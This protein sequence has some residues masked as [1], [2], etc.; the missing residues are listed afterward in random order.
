MDE[1]NTGIIGEYFYRIENREGPDFDTQCRSWVR[2]QEENT[3]PHINS[4]F[5]PSC[6]CSLTQAEL[7]S[8]FFPINDAS[9]SELVLCYQFFSANFIGNPV[10]AY[11]FQVCCYSNSTEDA[12][13]LIFNEVDGGNLQV[14]YFN[15]PNDV[16]NDTAAKQV[17]CIDSN[18]CDEFYDVRPSDTCV[19]YIP[20]ESGEQRQ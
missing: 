14:L 15:Q 6:P 9:S 3:M 2:Y 4:S 20:P 7:D 13:A 11:V 16:L 19:R 8:F 17:C 1:G 5:L 12:G 18:N 10:F